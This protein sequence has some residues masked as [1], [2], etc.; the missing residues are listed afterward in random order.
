[1]L[2]KVLCLIF[3]ITYNASYQES[4]TNNLIY[5]LSHFDSIVVLY[6]NNIHNIEQEDISLIKNQ[7]DILLENSHEMPA[8]GVSIHNETLKEIKSGLWIKLI[9]NHSQ[10]YC[11]MSFDELLIKITPNDYGLNIIRGN[12]GIYEGRCYYISLNLDTYDLHNQIIKIIKNTSS[13]I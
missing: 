2:N 7:F 9:Y 10:N 11:D 5:Y 8:L 4:Y 3:A 12:N 1:M 6:D 13:T